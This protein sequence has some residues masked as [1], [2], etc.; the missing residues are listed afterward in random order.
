M[1]KEIRFLMKSNL[2][3]YFGVRLKL[4]YKKGEVDTSKRETGLVFSHRQI[5][6]AK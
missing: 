2:L 3:I 1:L 4:M 5:A 6:N